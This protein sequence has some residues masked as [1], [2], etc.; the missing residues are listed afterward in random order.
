[1]EALD[2]LSSLLKVD[3]ASDL[4]TEELSVLEYCER[5]RQILARQSMEINAELHFDIPSN[6]KVQFYP[7]YLESVLFNL[8]SNA[9]R[10]HNPEKE[11]WVKVW[12]EDEPNFTRLFV[13]DNGLGID[14]EKHG[15]EIFKYR[16]TVHN[17]P[18]SS[19]IGLYLIRS[20]I[21]SLGGEISF[22]SILGEGSTFCISIPK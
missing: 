13:A 17:H 7:A 1:M 3:S 15:D 14:M 18:D 19:G 8:I 16:K 4:P 22:K 10:Y 2:E 11:P 5:V 20:Q 21:E 6:F 12:Q 9:L